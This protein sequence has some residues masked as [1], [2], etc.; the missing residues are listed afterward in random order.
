[1]PVVSFVL[2]D[3]D[4]P[5][6]GTAVATVTHAG[7]L[8]TVR[9]V[10]SDGRDWAMVPGSLEVG[11]YAGLRDAQRD[12]WKRSGLDNT[13]TVNQSATTSPHYAVPG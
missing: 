4:A 12:M 7:H 3:V 5:F 1:M 6:Y 2:T 11:R 10:T 13:A 8:G 9:A